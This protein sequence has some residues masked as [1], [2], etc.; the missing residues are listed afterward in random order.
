ML[1]LKIVNTTCRNWLP[2]LKILAVLACVVVRVAA[3]DYA[4]NNDWSKTDNPWLYHQCAMYIQK[5]DKEAVVVASVASNETK[6]PPLIALAAK[7]ENKSQVEGSAVEEW[8][9]PN[10]PSATFDSEQSSSSS[11]SSSSLSAM[12]AMANVSAESSSSDCDTFTAEPF[13]QLSGCMEIGAY[14]DQNGAFSREAC[15]NQCLRDA[16]CRAIQYGSEE[17]PHEC[18]LYAFKVG[19]QT[20]Y[21]ECRLLKDNIR[22]LWDV[23]VLNSRCERRPTEA[24]ESTCVVEMQQFWPGI[25]SSFELVGCGEQ[26]EQFTSPM[27]EHF[28]Q[29]EC[30]R[31][32]LTRTWCRTLLVE[33][34]RC[35]GLSYD[36]EQ[37]EA[38]AIRECSGKSD[39]E[40]RNAQC[41]LQRP[42]K[43][44]T[45]RS[46]LFSK[47]CSTI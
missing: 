43:R 18:R 40:V 27:S 9:R 26:S 15:L 35:T 8:L 32:C 36:V 23:H 20:P 10:E 14:G 46:K 6:P 38:H 12:S 7:M 31:M 41:R 44:R 37:L 25:G 19:D 42:K 45:V 21:G 1:T 13:T 2:K 24:P 39:D 47:S 29:A 11:S 30:M 16:N 3:E 34:R 28:S 33:G 17:C 22:Q 5:Y 4:E